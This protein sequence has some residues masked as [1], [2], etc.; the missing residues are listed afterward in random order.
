MKKDRRDVADEMVGFMLLL[1]DALLIL[2]CPREWH[3]L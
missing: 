2:F 1:L 3:A